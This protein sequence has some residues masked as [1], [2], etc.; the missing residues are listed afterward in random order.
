MDWHSSLG[1]ASGIIQIFSV[2]PYVKDMLYGNTRPNAVS[3]VLWAITGIIAVLAQVSAGASWSLAFLIALTFNACLIAFL[4]LRGYGYKKYTALDWSCLLL[5]IASLVLWKITENPVVA[6][7][8]SV[9][10]DFFAALPTIAKAYKDP[11][12]ELAFGWFLVVIASSL[13]ILSSTKWNTAN[14]I[15]PMYSLG[16]SALITWLVYFGQRKIFKRI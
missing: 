1:I 9:V 8:L 3:Y 6:L 14:L 11:N 7:V 15:V 12:S 13:S 5:A 16:E 4:S 10:G 2:I